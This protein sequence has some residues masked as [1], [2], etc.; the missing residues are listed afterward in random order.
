[1]TEAKFDEETKISS[2]QY[3][4]ELTNGGA[5]VEGPLLDAV[6]NF[7]L[8]FSMTEHRL[9]GENAR[10]RMSNVYATHYIDVAGLSAQKIYTYFLD[11][12]TVRPDHSNNLDD[13]CSH[14]TDSKT[15]ILGVMQ[16]KSATEKEIAEC[17]FRIII[18][19]RHNL[20]HGRKWS[21][22]LQGQEENLY[23]ACT[24]LHG[25]LSATKNQE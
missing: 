2:Y 13:L 1:M 8:L 23:G 21:Y 3:I 5:R 25:Y 4:N 20:F 10:T 15:F 22:N 9:M 16:N 18:R 11:R 19:L 17:V 24:F 14:D 7:T 6:F 12:Y